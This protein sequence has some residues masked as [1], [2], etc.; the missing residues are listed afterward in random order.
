MRRLRNW[1]HSNTK[2]NLLLIELLL[3][4]AL[5]DATTVQITASETAA[6]SAL[7]NS[8]VAVGVL[9]EW[10][11]VQMLQPNCPVQLDAGAAEVLKPCA[12]RQSR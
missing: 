5:L 8:L 7:Q 6:G 3:H 12:C 11:T 9:C 10:G 4:F 1:Q 2:S